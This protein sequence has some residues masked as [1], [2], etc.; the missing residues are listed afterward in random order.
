MATKKPASSIKQTPAKRLQ[1]LQA[2]RMA[3]VNWM[4]SELKK[5]LR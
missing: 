4:M 3:W 5:E 2:T 1:K